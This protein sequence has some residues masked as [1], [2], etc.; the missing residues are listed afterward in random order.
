MK[1]ISIV[2][3]L[4]IALA[5]SAHADVKAGVEAW[6][7]GD[8]NT[9]IKEWRPLAIKGDADAQ[10]NLGQAYKLGRGVPAD[11][12]AAEQWYAKAAAQGHWQAEDN[13]GLVMYQNGD[14]DQAMPYL[15]KSAARGEP[16]AQYILGIALFNG[17]V[18]A[19]DWPRAYALITRASASGMPSAS[20]ALAQM[21]Q[22]IPVEQ[23]Q[24]GLTMARDMELASARPKFDGTASA[25]IMAAARPSGPSAPPPI[26][27][28]ELPAS[29]APG[30]TY[31]VR[32]VA[33]PP[34][35]PAPR[36][37]PVRAASAPATV[38]AT[39]VIRA[40]GGK[41]WRIQL[42][43]F[44]DQSRARALWQSVEGRVANLA[45][46]TPYLVQAGSV[47]RLQ[48]GNLASRSAAERICS[49]VQSAGNSCLV[50]AP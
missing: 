33:P 24:Q 10:F 3:V 19:K 7:K 2:A 30:A 43:A 9:A 8:Y 21:D 31:D 20:R 16:R 27:S 49:E 37:T 17:D 48:G 40:T 18:I 46:L 44:G 22:Q 15:E 11:L 34:V 38:A 6:S 29:S 14:R 28:E 41:G 42:G 45:S 4:A 23:R 25:P 32:P 13:L 47:T 50:V 5:S 12:K 36:P 26:R 39:P 1:R 35:R